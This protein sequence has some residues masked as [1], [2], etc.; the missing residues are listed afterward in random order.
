MEKNSSVKLGGL[1]NKIGEK[2]ISK[3]SRTKKNM[4]NKGIT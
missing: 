3:V 2:L 4:E 1:Q